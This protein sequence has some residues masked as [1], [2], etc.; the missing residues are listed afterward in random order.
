MIIFSS[1]FLFFHLSPK[2][3]KIVYKFS[4]HNHSPTP[5]FKLASFQ[6]L[7]T[8]HLIPSISSTIYSMLQPEQSS[9]GTTRM[10]L[11]LPLS[12]C[13]TEHLRHGLIG[14]QFRNQHDFPFRTLISHLLYDTG[15][16][17]NYLTLWVYFF[18]CLKKNNGVIPSS[19]RYWEYHLLIISISNELSPELAYINSSIKNIY[20]SLN[21]P[22]TFS[23]YFFTPRSLLRFIFSSTFTAWQNPTHSLESQLQML[24]PLWRF[25]WSPNPAPSLSLLCTFTFWSWIIKVKMQRK[26]D[27]SPTDLNVNPDSTTHSVTL[28]KVNLLLILSHSFFITKY[29]ALEI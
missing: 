1:V 8:S 22:N 27:L 25:F 13:P 6:A 21:S 26:V 12:W 18:I 2:P 5:A 10:E 28:N 3:S 14:K 7:T 17:I 29:E 9:K 24:P 11:C 16:I 4:P 23:Q 20:Y 15:Q 19:E